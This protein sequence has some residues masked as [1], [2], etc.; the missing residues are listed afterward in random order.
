ML[1]LSYGFPSLYMKDGY[2]DSYANVS[3]VTE[4]HYMK[5]IKQIK[6]RILIKYANLI[7]I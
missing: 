7:R 3:L 2:D 1:L 5:K 4:V 6:V